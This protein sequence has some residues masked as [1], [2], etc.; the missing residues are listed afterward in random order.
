MIGFSLLG[1]ICGAFLA[2]FGGLIGIFYQLVK[3]ASIFFKVAFCCEARLERRNQAPS[4]S[5]IPTSLDSAGLVT[6]NNGLED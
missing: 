4:A 2:A 6:D 3:V 5:P 1:A